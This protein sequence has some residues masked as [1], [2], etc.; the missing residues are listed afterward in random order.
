MS[1]AADNPGSPIA[2]LRAHPLAKRYSDVRDTSVRLCETLATEDY[3]VQPTADVSPPKWHLAHTTWFFEELLLVKFSPGYKRFNETFPA[4]FNSYYKAAG[5]HWLQSERGQLSRPTVREIFNYRAHVD[6]AMMELLAADTIDDSVENEM[7]TLLE[8]GIH[9]EQQHQELL[10]MDIK[11]ILGVNPQPPKY[12]T[13]PLPLAG[14]PAGN[15]HAINSGNFEIGF[16]GSEFCFDNETPRHTIFSPNAMVSQSMISNGEYLAFMEDGGYERPAYWLSMGWDWVT[17]TEV[18]Q[19]LYWHRKADEWFEFSLHGI[20]PLDLNAPVAHISY[21]EAN[22]YACWRGMRLPTEPELEIFLTRSEAQQQQQVEDDF[23]AV[24][25]NTSQGQ[26]WCWTSSPYSAYPGYKPYAGM[27]GEYNGK[28]MCNQ[29][30]LR[31]GC[32]ATPSGHYRNSYRNFYQPH[33]RWMFSGIR[34]A[35]DAA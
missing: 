3:V 30:V 29:F 9:H 18:R 20:N 1:N 32:I 10:L 17:E 23:H 6:S 8:I 26:L 12:S 21:F 15:W 24:N 25:C 33:Q 22:A 34:L 4:L 13:A 16:E 31:G 14:P 2:H 19:P 7:F 27:L 5:T 11:Y 35:K 28:F